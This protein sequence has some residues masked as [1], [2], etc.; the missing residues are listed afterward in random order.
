MPRLRRA[1]TKLPEV[2]RLLAGRDLSCARDFDPLQ[3]A[4][5][6][7]RV[8]AEGLKKCRFDTIR[9]DTDALFC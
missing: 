5:G 8:L 9:N 2:I 7:R 1:V 4:I 6:M 3:C